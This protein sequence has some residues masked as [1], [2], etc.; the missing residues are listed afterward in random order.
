MEEVKGAAGEKAMF[1][2]RIYYISGFDRRGASYYYGLFSQQ[3]KR[4]SDLTGR[5][6]SVGSRRRD[7]LSLLSRWR[8]NEVD[9]SSQA[10]CDFDYCFLHWDDIVRQSWER[11]PLRLLGAGL[12][13]YGDQLMQGV[14]WR[15]ARGSLPGIICFLY[16]FL[17]F[18][19]AFLLAGLLGSL[20]FSA[21]V[22]LAWLKPI[23]LELASAVSLTILWQAWLL[24]DRLG[25]LWL[26]LFRGRNLRQSSAR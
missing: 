3:L 15:I 1:E 20:A 23:S 19:C 6:L 13:L 7:A 10:G 21:T 22:H 4:F 8:V 5:A 25:I 17:F 24:A 12:V 16:P 2:R 14:L 11:N 18:A 9:P 26:Y